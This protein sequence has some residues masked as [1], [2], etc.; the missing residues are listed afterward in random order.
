MQDDAFE[1]IVYSKNVVEFVTVANE[2]CNFIDNN[3]SFS[4]SE[5]FQ[6]L[7]KLLP[8]LYLKASLIPVIEDNDE[9]VPEKFLS[10]ID[11]N[12]MLNKLS[13]K[14]GGYDSYLEVFDPRI[15]YSEGPV[16]ANISED[17]C[18]IYQDLFDFIRA[19]KVGIPDVMIA[20]LYECN[21]NF[22][23]FWGQKLVNSLRAIH[24]LIYSDINPDWE[25]NK[26]TTSPKTQQDNKNNW[27][28]NYFN[29][30]SSSEDIE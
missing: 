1:H 19:Y 26:K 12:H 3:V 28:A 7:Q 30:H 22:A 4:N 9:N 16:Q 5:L 2:F 29:N 15:Q 11:Y 23:E 8:L 17:L 13:S 24:S 20:A 6:K 10:E 27:V 14:F 25:V 21:N 18:D